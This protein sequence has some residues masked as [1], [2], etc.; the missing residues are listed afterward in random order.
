VQCRSR[1]DGLPTAYELEHD[2]AVLDYY[3]LPTTLH[4]HYTARS[5]K[6]A[7]IETIPVDRNDCILPFG[8]AEHGRRI[9]DVAAGHLQTLVV[10]LHGGWIAREGGYYVAHLQGTLHHETAG[11]TGRTKDQDSHTTTSIRSVQRADSWTSSSR[12]R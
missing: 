11:S 7:A 4:L 10:A 1:L 8:R 9:E 12:W 2:T 5:G 6:R 3:E